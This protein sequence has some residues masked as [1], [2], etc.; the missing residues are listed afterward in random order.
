[1][2]QRAQNGP[3]FNRRGKP[4]TYY[5]LLATDLF[6]GAPH[7]IA[8]TYNADTSQAQV[9]LDGTPKT[10]RDVPGNPG[11][12]V[13]GG[14]FA[15][16]QDPDNVDE[17][18]EYGF[19]PEQIFS[20]EIS[21]VR[22]YDEVRSAAQI[23]LDMI[24]PLD[25][26]ALPASLAHAWQMRVGSDLTSGADIVG[27]KH[28]TVSTN[29]YGV[30][31]PSDGD[32]A[33]AAA[34]NG[35]SSDAVTVEMT[36]SHGALATGAVVPLLSYGT[37]TNA[38][39]FTVIAEEDAINGDKL[40]LFVN[41]VQQTLV[42]GEVVTDLFDGGIH[43]LALVWNSDNDVAAVYIDGA[44][45][46]SASFTLGT[47]VESGGTFVLG[48]RISGFNGGDPVFSGEDFSGV[49]YEVRVYDDVRT[50]EQI[51][52]DMVT[53]LD[54]LN[55]PADLRNGWQFLVSGGVPSGTDITGGDDLFLYYFI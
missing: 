14:V 53:P 45:A 42:Q 52:I 37:T 34:Y 33:K 48:Q 2:S 30:R 21:D 22:I 16:G 6:D 5:W 41:G 49:I 19:N 27:G 20:R 51:L 47:T 13:A 38:D 46:G 54:A 44:L 11:P 1:M 9:F 50:Q 4:A 8:L 15:L 24:T 17:N 36:F 26:A 32:Y 10:V 12:A 23:Q 3:R 18:D 28:L 43:H 7:H 40:S 29:S 39:A 55:L 25:P 35:F 31:F